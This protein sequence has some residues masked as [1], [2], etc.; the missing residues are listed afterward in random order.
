M[1]LFFPSFLLPL[2]LPP[3]A[4]FSP[5]SVY[6][7]IIL[8]YLSPASFIFP[9]L[10]LSLFTCLFSSFL[11]LPPLTSFAP[12]SLRPRD[13]QRRQIGLFPLPTHPRIRLRSFFPLKLPPV[14]PV[15]SPNWVPWLVALVRSSLRRRPTLPP[16]LLL[17]VAPRM[18]FPS[19]SGRYGQMMM[20]W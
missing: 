18:A 4:S 1:F 3:A 8:L 14:F 15:T 17:P 16:R 2:S 20:C 10:F 19:T 5:S 6:L 7:P 13:R 12:S 11:P 9:C